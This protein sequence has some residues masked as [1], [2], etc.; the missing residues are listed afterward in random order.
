MIFD[1]IILK[2]GIKNANA[3]TLLMMITL[4]LYFSTL[5]P[6]AL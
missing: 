1:K 5:T 2:N 3:I 4:A 6:N